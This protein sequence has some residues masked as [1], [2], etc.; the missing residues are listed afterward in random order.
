MTEIVDFTSPLLEIAR[1]GYLATVDSQG[2]PYVTP[3]CFA[4]HSGSLYSVLDEK[5]KRVKTKRLRRVRNIQENPRV[6]LLVDHYEEDWD[7]LWYIM[8]WGL[9]DLLLEGV[10]RVQAIN[11][12]REKYP[13]YRSM[14]IVQSPV[15]KIIPSRVISW[16]LDSSSGI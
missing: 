13:Q 9:A 11:I 15:I 6:S 12:L 1:V 4:K 2:I 10:E 7:N 8:V 14:D 16:G 3:V 5:P